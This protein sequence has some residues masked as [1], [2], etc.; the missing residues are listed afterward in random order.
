MN[1]TLTKKECELLWSIF[2]GTKN[3]M[4]DILEVANDSKNGYMNDFSDFEK[5][6]ILDLQNKMY[7][8]LDDEVSEIEPLI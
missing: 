4:Y 3:N 2:N 5:K 6:D 1:I 8:D 7:N